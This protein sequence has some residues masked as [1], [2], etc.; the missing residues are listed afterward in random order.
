M[1]ADEKWAYLVELDETLLKGG[2]VLSEWT[3]ALVKNADLAFVGEANLAVIITALAAIETHL[4]GEG[5]NAT[6]RL[7]QLI[8]EASIEEDLRAELTFLRKYRNRWVHISE[9]WDDEKLIQDE[10]SHEVEIEEIAKRSL[11]ALRR[12]I[13]SNPR[14]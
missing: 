6:G 10:S 1:T 12:V 13:Y 7:V 9:P 8:A 14:V 5:G 3:T 2:A 11:S 4:R